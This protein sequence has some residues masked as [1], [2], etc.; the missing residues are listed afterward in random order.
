M[1]TSYQAS[2]LAGSGKAQQNIANTTTCDRFRKGL[3]RFL[4][5]RSIRATPFQYWHW[6]MA[7]VLCDYYLVVSLSDAI[8]IQHDHARLQE[9]ATG[10]FSKASV[11]KNIYN[12]RHFMIGRIYAAVAYCKGLLRSNSTEWSL[13]RDENKPVSPFRRPIIQ[14]RKF[15]SE[16][17]CFIVSKNC[18]S[19]NW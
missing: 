4:K 14:P 9:A 3:S 19:P 11:M 1:A 16:I 8:M 6:T 12:A 17:Q 18:V 2:A 10:T 7:Y 15:H 5:F 13:F